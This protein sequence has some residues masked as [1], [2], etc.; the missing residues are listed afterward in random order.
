M[1]DQSV[2]EILQAMQDRNR[3]EMDREKAMQLLAGAPTPEITGDLIDALEDND[4]GIRWAAAEVLIE[5][6]DAALRPMLMALVEKHDSTWL[7]EGAYRVFHDTR[8]LKVRNV[9]ADLLPAL[10]GPA[11]GLATTD[12]AVQALAK[13]QD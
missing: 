11:A 10:K 6:G 4:S 8:S 13:L 12:A 7:R 2:H 3:P 1:S 5:M 9:T